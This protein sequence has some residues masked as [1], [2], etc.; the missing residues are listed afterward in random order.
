MNT[1]YLFLLALTKWDVAKGFVYTLLSLFLFA[2]IVVVLL[3]AISRQ[4][5]KDN[6]P[7]APERHKYPPSD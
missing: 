2:V 5:K 3:I 7:N 4:K 1:I 6:L